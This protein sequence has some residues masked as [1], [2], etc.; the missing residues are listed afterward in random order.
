M[1]ARS[2]TAASRAPARPHRQVGCRKGGCLIPPAPA[3]C[4][5]LAQPFSVSGLCRCLIGALVRML[6]PEAIEAEVAFGL[7]LPGFGGL[8]VTL[9]AKMGACGT[10]SA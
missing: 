1:R 7:R 4:A 5:T 9:A 6:S 3:R 2:W 8:V 10:P